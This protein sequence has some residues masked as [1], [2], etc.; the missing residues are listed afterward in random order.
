MAA[1]VGCIAGEEV[2]RQWRGGGLSGERLGRRATPFGD[3]GEVY[4]VTSEQRPFYLLARYAEGLQKTPP[5]QVN[6]RANL[7]ALK[8][9]GVRAVLAW[10]PGGAIRHNLAAGDL[11]LLDDLIDYTYRRANT[12]FDDR[13]LGYLRQF[14]VFCPTV[15]Q[16]ARDS[17]EA[18]HLACHDGGTAAV[19]EGPRLETPAEVRMLAAFGAAIVTHLFAPESFLA[20]ELQLCYAAVCY[21]VNFAETGSTHEPFA[22]GGLFGGL[23]RKSDADRVAETLQAMPAVAA[24]VAA[25]V[26]DAE[27]PCPCGEALARRVRELGLP[28]DWHQWF[29]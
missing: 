23:A 5:H 4:L 26:E 7:Y 27:A 29:A 9:L 18:L 2:H 14:P 10:G 11:V 25:A 21:V 15:R 1:A 28:E 12:F 13:P 8:D 24:S 17:L 22:A 19:R 6:D 3:S 20:R 16:A